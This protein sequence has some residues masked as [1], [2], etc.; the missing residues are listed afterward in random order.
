MGKLSFNFQR[1]FLW[2]SRKLQGMLKKRS[3]SRW[4]NVNILWLCLNNFSD[5]TKFSKYLS[6]ND[7]SMLRDISIERD[8]LQLLFKKLAFHVISIH[9]FLGRIHIDRDGLRT[10]LAR[11]KQTANMWVENTEGLIHR[12]KSF[13]V[14]SQH[15]SFT[16]L[17][18]W[19]STWTSCSLR[20]D[21]KIIRTR[22]SNLTES[23][24]RC[25]SSAQIWNAGTREFSG[26]LLVWPPFLLLIFSCFT[27]ES[28]SLLSVQSRN[29]NLTTD[30]DL[31]SFI[32]TFR[33]FSR[34][35]RTIYLLES[36][37]WPLTLVWTLLGSLTIHLLSL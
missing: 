36:I 9:L 17:P 12:L 25:Q 24:K 20:C 2:V 11:N 23:S 34:S 1:N 30:L 28:C 7:F 29:F 8:R 15:I 35:F 19:P 31:D 37:L 32:K 21:G 3:W 22:G 18:I 26:G 10:V 5:S 14:S 27:L 33:I 13:R 6:N 4:K 16:Y